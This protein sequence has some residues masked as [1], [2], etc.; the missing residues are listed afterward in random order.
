MS[1]LRVGGWSA[2][3]EAMEVCRAEAE[4]A[5]PPSERARRGESPVRASRAVSQE[6]EAVLKSLEA[7]SKGLLFISETDAPFAPVNAPD[8]KFAALDDAAVRALA[9]HPAGD[10]VETISVDT[11]FR[12]AVQDQPWHTP[13]EAQTVKKYRALVKH[14]H[15]KLPDAK[16]YRVG[17]V[18]IDVLIL[19][20]GPGGGA[21][22][23]RTKVVET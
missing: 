7:A 21:L 13:Q 22:G 2:S 16:V 8:K 11:L 4:H 6:R 20:T 12:N 10:P 3:Y 15:E 9:G 5:A 19:G 17:R 1:V 14:L 23:L 18:E